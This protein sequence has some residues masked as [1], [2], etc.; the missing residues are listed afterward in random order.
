MI[1]LSFLFGILGSAGAILLMSTVPILQRNVSRRVAPHVSDVSQAAFDLTQSNRRGDWV[2]GVICAGMSN[3]A[4]R[5]N[6]N[7][8][9][10]ATIARQAAVAGRAHQVRVSAFTF[11]VAGT[12]VGLMLATLSTGALVKYVIL[13]V[14]CGAVGAAIPIVRV[15]AQ[16]RRR[17]ERIERE[18][19]TVLEFLALCVSAGEGLPDAF[20]R[21]AKRGAG[22]LPAEFSEIVRQTSF[23]RPFAEALAALAEE[24]RIPSFERLVM[25]LRAALDRGSPLSDV[26]RAQA[27]DLRVQSRRALMESAGRKEIWMM[28]PL[29]FLILPT[30]IL[31]A[32]WPGVI[33]L[34]TGF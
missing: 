1:G 9:G 31:F 6:S 22:A 34:N 32:V 29:V 24:L 23:G 2:R 13:S 15:R 17:V 21:I 33:A 18:L 30:T 16:A 7:G 12:A 25:Q 26:L 19:P 28:I 8:L 10:I 14:V 20:E 11:G 5:F 3:A 4:N 27:S